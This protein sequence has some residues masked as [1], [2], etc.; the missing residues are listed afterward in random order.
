[1]PIQFPDFQRISFQE[2]NPLL[3]GFATGSSALAKALTDYQTARINNQY[4]Q[5][6]SKYYQSPALQ[7]RGLTNVGKSFVEAPIVRSILQNYGANQPNQVSPYNDGEK[8]INENQNNQDIQN[9][10]NPEG[11]ED[12]ISNAYQLSRQKQTTDLDTRKR[13]L[14]ASNIDKTTKYIN[15]EHL[16]SYSGIGGHIK[17]AIDYGN[18]SQNKPSERFQNYQKALTAAQ[19]L[20]KQTRQFYGA[21]ITPQMDKQLNELVNPESWILD[22]DTAIKKYHQLM[23]ILKNE[24][25]TYRQALKSRKAYEEQNENPISK[26]INNNKN[27]EVIRVWNEK[28]RRL[29]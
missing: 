9:N 15:P 8:N 17:K 1:M 14:F 27:G 18:A 6:L 4:K 11:N 26:E 20:A 24:T 23:D 16:F 25:G 12:D 22:K 13:N 5:A 2:A 7:E 3:T 29:E 28:T 19:L 21:S 10:Y